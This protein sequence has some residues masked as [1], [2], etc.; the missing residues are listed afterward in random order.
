MDLRVL[1]EP[2]LPAVIKDTVAFETGGSRS[3]TCSRDFLVD[4]H[5]GKEFS[6]EHQGALSRFFEDVAL[7]RK[8]PM[9]FATHEIRDV[10]TTLAIAIFLTGT[11]CSSQG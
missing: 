3:D 11:S 9:T 6:P 1:I 8:I 7:G 4:E 2:A 5:H 10:D